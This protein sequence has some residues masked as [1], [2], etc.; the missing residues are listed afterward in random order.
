MRSLGLRTLCMQLLCP[1]QRKRRRRAPADCLWSITPARPPHARQQHAPAPTRGGTY[2][3]TPTV[4]HARGA[5]GG[6]PLQHAPGPGQRQ[7]RRGPSAHADARRR[8]RRCAVLAAAPAQR[9]RGTQRA[10][11]TPAPLWRP[12]AT[13]AAGPPARPAP[14]TPTHCSTPASPSTQAAAAQRQRMAPAACHAQ[15]A[16][17]A[18][19]CEN[20]AGARVRRTAIPPHRQAC[21]RFG[22]VFESVWHL[23]VTRG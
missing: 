18:G 3:H 8:P 4:R 6:M 19:R 13:A 5:V 9:V 1:R 11:G 15:G 22:V 10:A 12:G 20:A 17:A 7:A 16:P 14:C 21:Y 23:S 2:H